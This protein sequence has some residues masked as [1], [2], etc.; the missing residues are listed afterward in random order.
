MQGFFELLAAVALLIWVIGPLARK[1]YE[2]DQFA[3]WRATAE[4]AED[5]VRS[6]PFEEPLA[7]HPFYRPVGR[8]RG[9]PL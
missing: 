7:S 3:K 5:D 8:R 1:Q 2:T 4:D 9:T 6:E